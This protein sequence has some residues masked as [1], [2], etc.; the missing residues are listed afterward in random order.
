MNPSRFIFQI[1]I[2]LKM[3]CEPSIYTQLIIF[4]QNIEILP[5]AISA[6]LQTWNK[7]Y[8][9]CIWKLASQ[10]K[11]YKLHSAFH[12]E[13]PF[14]ISSNC[15]LMLYTDQV[16]YITNY[17]PTVQVNPSECAPEATLEQPIQLPTVCQGDGN[18]KKIMSRGTGQCYKNRFPWCLMSW[19]HELQ[20]GREAAIL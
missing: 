8:L 9:K 7:M 10:C 15:I 17:R 16:E 3:Q 18:I 5:N 13:K 6:I 20:V 2:W 1:T 11:W 12:G 14:L 19:N 4:Q